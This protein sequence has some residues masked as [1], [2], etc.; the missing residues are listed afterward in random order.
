VDH[1]QEQGLILAAQRGDRNAVGALYDA[2]ADSI[3][4]YL[5]YRVNDRDTAEDLT[6]EVFLNFVEGISSYVMGE[7]PLIAWLYRVAH[8]RLVDHYRKQNRSAKESN[9]DDLVIGVEDDV[10]AQLM[11]DHNEEKVRFAMETLT[12]EQKQVIIFRFVE[13]YSLEKT[14]ELM[15]KTVGAIKVMQYR[16]V[17]SLS[18]AFNK[19]DAVPK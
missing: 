18:R 3:Y 19:Q 15:G 2:Y 17:Q 9:L 1:K 4:R 11:S 12:A 7:T 14:A 5:Y 6:A 8:A 10:D 13:S 16:A